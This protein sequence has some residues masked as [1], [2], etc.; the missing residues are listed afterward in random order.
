MSL[1]NASGKGAFFVARWV[2]GLIGKSTRDLRFR[3]PTAPLTRDERAQMA[4]YIVHFEFE[5]ADL[6]R[7]KH[8]YE[9]LFGWKFSD[10]TEPARYSLVDTRGGPSGG[11]CLSA[12]PV[13][14]FTLF[15]D[16]EDIDRAL[17]KVRE[18][19]GKT[20]EKDAITGVGWVA[21]CVDTEGNELTLFQSDEDA[22]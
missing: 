10:L 6:L 21:R 2:F 1:S 4:G 7:A 12:E 11:I 3:S 18:L 16:T 19:G 20:E 13:G 22:A 15:F 17:E 9:E 5:A 8:F 14:H